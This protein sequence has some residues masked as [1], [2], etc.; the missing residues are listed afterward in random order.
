MLPR[1][2]GNRVVRSENERP[3]TKW[4]S[5]ANSDHLVHEYTLTWRRDWEAVVREFEHPRYPHGVCRGSFHISFANHWQIAVLVRFLSF[6]NL[7]DSLA[8][9]VIRS[10]T[11]HPGSFLIPSSR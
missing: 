8:L 7:I 4:F 11:G 3:P 9:Y 1:L 5:Q 2:F 10:K 6:M